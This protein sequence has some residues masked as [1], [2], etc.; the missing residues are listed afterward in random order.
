M[1]FYTK[2]HEVHA[3]MMVYKVNWRLNDQPNGNAII[4]DSQKGLLDNLA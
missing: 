3:I 1:A 4:V 2:A